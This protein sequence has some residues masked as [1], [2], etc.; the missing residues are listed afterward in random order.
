M[1]NVTHTPKEVHLLTRDPSTT[2]T[3]R[4]GQAYEWTA[5]LNS[6][7]GW[8]RAPLHPDQ[9]R[10]LWDAAVEQGQ[11]AETGQPIT[12]RFVAR[13]EAGNALL[14]YANPP[15]YGPAEELVALVAV[16]GGYLAWPA[17]QG[18][19]F[20]VIGDHEGHQILI[21]ARSFHTKTLPQLIRQSPYLFACKRHDGIGNDFGAG[22]L[23]DCPPVELEAD[24]DAMAE[25]ADF[26]GRHL[27]HGRLVGAWRSS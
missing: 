19:A 22:L 18:A 10:L 25:F 23:A 6:H 16:K 9:A 26:F 7:L 8:L 4:S 3:G 21:R 27:L 13:F 14:A 11:V 5:V 12:G 20:R 17:G 1:S 2:P 15:D 24:L